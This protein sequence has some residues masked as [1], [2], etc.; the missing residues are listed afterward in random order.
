MGLYK[1]DVKEAVI[2]CG[3][4][5]GETERRATILPSGAR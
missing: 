5:A 4:L 3:A 1:G 2:W